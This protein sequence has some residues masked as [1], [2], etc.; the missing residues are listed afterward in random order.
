MSSATGPLRPSTYRVS[1]VGTLGAA[2]R[3]AL[4]DLGVTCAAPST[5]F[6]VTLGSRTRSEAE[7]EA[8][9][10]EKGLV[11]LSARRVHEP[12]AQTTDPQ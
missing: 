3:S 10:Q 7:L 5:V 12:Q 1:V 9:L 8:K 6:R 11:L 4:A 2:V